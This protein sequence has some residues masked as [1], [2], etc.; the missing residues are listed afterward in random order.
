MMNQLSESELKSFLGKKVSDDY[1]R[2]LGRIISV[3]LNSFG[4][5]EEVE[6]EKGSGELERIPMEQLT[7]AG[8]AVIAIS[9]WKTEVEVLLKEIA[10]AQRRMDAL[11]ALIKREEMPKNLYEELLRKQ[12]DGLENLR[13]KKSCAIKVLQGRN[14]DLDSQVEELTKMLIEIRAGKWSK[15]F[16]KR[17]YEVASK[18]IEPNLEFVTKERK[19]LANYLEKLTKLL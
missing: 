12:E 14:R 8:D 3:K 9:R 13:E 11:V 6:L 5:M 19:E 1:G 17:A 2:S 16:S 7:I 4:E 18:S 10:S 15:D